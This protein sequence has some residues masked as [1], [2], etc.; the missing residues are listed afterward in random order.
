MT[1]QLLT[2]IDY[3][4]QSGYN[5]MI[6]WDLGR[7]CNYDCTYCTLY[8]HNSWSEHAKME[9]LKDTMRNIHEYYSI[10]K[11]FHKFKFDC[12]I[13]FTGGEPTVNP[14]Y[15]KFVEWIRENY[16]N[17]YRL[18]MTT[19]GTWN[20]DTA[21]K[22]LKNF[23]M[24]TISYHTEA[25][26][27]L[28]KK[29]VENI[30]HLHK[31]GQ[32]FKVNV[33][34]HADDQYFNECVDLMENVLTPMGIPFIPRIIGDKGVKETQKQEV[35]R[36]KNKVITRNQTHTYTPEQA[37]YI[38]MYWNKKNQELKD[39]HAFSDIKTNLDP[40]ESVSGFF[41]RMS[42][43]KQIEIEEIPFAFMESKRTEIND[44]NNF[45][46][47]MDNKKLDET[48]HPDEILELY[49]REQMIEEKKVETNASNMFINET[50]SDWLDNT[51]LVEPTNPVVLPFK[52]GI[53]SV[54]SNQD[55][56]NI[57]KDITD[58]KKSEKGDGKIVGR[59]LGRM[60]CGG[61]DIS[62]QNVNS[63]PEQ[64]DE[65]KFV[66]D[67]RFT[68]WKC[69]IN[70]FFLHIEQEKDIIYHHQTCRHSLNSVEEPIGKVS[71]FKEMN[72]KL[73]E[74]MFGNMEIPFITCQRPICG[75]GMCVPK[76]KD[77]AVAKQLFNKYVKS[78]EPIE[79]TYKQNKH[80]RDHMM[81]MREYK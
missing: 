52:E 39:K 18:S 34:M 1:E 32:R 46:K 22:I 33:M 59:S 51:D 30:L 27:T 54:K 38:L 61:R 42:K 43:S 65:V 14:S 77:P 35:D 70:W 3:N 44:W 2:A 37:E 29:V 36:K 23:N 24:I 76:A 4:Q 67:T 7:R 45:S 60:C 63:M 58:Y 6:V 75:C 10:Y 26:P 5:M 71:K 47:W 25:H 74:S 11:T 13:S 48:H 49:K 53:D 57:V 16:G 66:T 55:P 73:R 12:T 28:K 80:L 21:D 56:L 20:L 64:W 19:N 9:E 31:I 17:Q 68:G 62:C 50:D 15:F 40:E 72:D 79:P 41:D 69:M 8:M 78:L 81:K